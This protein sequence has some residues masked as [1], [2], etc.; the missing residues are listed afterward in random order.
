M[1]VGLV[2]VKME[3]LK[4]LLLLSTIIK[5]AKKLSLAPGDYWTVGCRERTARGGA[6]PSYSNKKRRNKIFHF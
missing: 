6:D 4:V 1:I 2:E 5:G 3:Q